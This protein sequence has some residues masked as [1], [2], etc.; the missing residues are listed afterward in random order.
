MDKLIGD[1]ANLSTKLLKEPTQTSVEELSNLLRE[2]R[3]LCAS[4]ADIRRSLFDSLDLNLLIQLFDL[5]LKQDQSQSS[6]LCVK[7]G[8]QVIGN[9]VVQNDIQCVEQI[10]NVTGAFLLDCFKHKDDKMNIIVMMV[11]FNI[12]KYLPNI[13]ESNSIKTTVLEQAIVGNEFAIYFLEDLIY[14]TSKSE[15]TSFS[16]FF[17]SL[18]IQHQLYVME[19]IKTN[20]KPGV[21]LDHFV[22]MF[23]KDAFRI[24]SDAADISHVQTTVLCLELLAACSS[25]NE[26]Q[27]LLQNNA[28]FVS[29]VFE[30]LKA[31]HS[32]GKQDKDNKF[33]PDQNLSNMFSLDENNEVFGL[34]ATCV[35]LVANL[36]W[37]HAA[38]QNLARISECFPVLLECCNLDA[39][40]PLIKEWAVFAIR[41]CCE[42]NMVNQ[43]LIA[44]MNQTNEPTIDTSV[45]LNLAPGVH[46][47][48]LNKHNTCSSVFWDFSVLLW[49]HEKDTYDTLRMYL[50]R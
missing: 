43:Q 26:Y 31:M 30:F 41:N 44:Q 49:Q 18:P 21:H 10:W 50:W 8:L 39:R 6:L 16:Q 2:F 32:L 27:G 9:T 45:G 19:Y 28:T 24:L 38:N 48:P 5:V 1:F 11:L 42:N 7:I 4:N 20:I 12:F 14:F 13:V 47:G 3:T 35:K 34:K 15:S 40:N 29:S 33:A 46:I 17:E 37:G 36:C 23:N 22:H 25:S